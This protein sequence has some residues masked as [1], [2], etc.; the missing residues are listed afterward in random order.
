MLAAITPSTSF[1][2]FT[3][4]RGEIVLAFPADQVGRAMTLPVSAP[5]PGHQPWFVGITRLDD[6]LLWV[7]DPLGTAS[8]AGPRTLIVAAG[9]HP[10]WAVAVDR[11]ESLMEARRSGIPTIQ[12][13]G[14]QACWPATWSKGC[15]LAD[16][17]RALLM[18][19]H[20]LVEALTSS[21]AVA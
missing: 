9:Q 12:A 6:R 15:L 20:I 4:L 11:V 2:A 18:D 3:A 13:A 21:R 19:P 10:R 17:R 7:F 5:V 8:P 1:Q 14:K 16:G